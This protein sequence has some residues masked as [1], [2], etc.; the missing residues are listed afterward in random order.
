MKRLFDL[1]FAGAML[2]LASPI[3]FLTM[4]VIFLQDYHWPLYSAARV[5]QDGCVFKII[6]LR[7][8]TV[9]ADRAGVDST[10]KNDPR[11]T[12]IGHFMRKYKLDELTELWNVLTGSMSVVGPRPNVE[13]ETKLYT[14][15]EQQLLSVKPGITDFSSIVFSDEGAILADAADPNLE[16]N[17]LI[18]PWKSRLG[19]FYIENGSLWLDVKLIWLTILALL[20]K[21]AALRGVVRQL[22]KLEAPDELIRIAQR[23][24]KL[25][26]HPPPGSDEIVTFRPLS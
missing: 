25:V 7:S 20:L 3:L 14:Q 12:S 4:L 21:K 10:S 1:L 11:I 16:Y 19:L 5:G 9:G 26:P 2:L 18:R 17:R 6:K 22:K 13:R 24:N 23:E 8:M 15:V